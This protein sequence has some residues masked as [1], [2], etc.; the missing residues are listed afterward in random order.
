MRQK[1]EKQIT[2]LKEHSEKASVENMHECGMLTKEV[3]LSQVQTA[4][5]KKKVEVLQEQIKS[6]EETLKAIEVSLKENFK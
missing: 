1:S 5:E 3:V 2:W 6:K 4:E